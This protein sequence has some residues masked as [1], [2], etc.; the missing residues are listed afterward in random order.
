MGYRFD[1]LR[2]PAGSRGD[3]P[4]IHVALAPCLVGYGEIVNWLNDQNDTRLEIDFWQ[5]GLDQSF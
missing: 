5:M 1:D 3:L 4:D 2:S